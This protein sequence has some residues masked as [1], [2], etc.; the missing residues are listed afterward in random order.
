MAFKTRPET[1]AD[2]KAIRSIIQAAFAAKSHLHHQ[3]SQIVDKLRASGNLDLSLVVEREG[4]VIGHISI[5]TVQIEAESERIDGWYGL[6]PLAVHP[7]WQR[8]GVGSELVNQA[9][10]C[11]AC[12]QQLQNLGTSHL[13]L[14]RALSPVYRRRC[15]HYI[16]WSLPRVDLLVKR[17]ILMTSRTQYAQRVQRMTAVE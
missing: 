16:T 17:Y 11:F 15:S 1:P 9:R 7:D 2:I 13:H 8:Q 3:E 4:A 10:A 14:V 5:S 12:L 6:G